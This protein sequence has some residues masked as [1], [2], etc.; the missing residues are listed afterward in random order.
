MFCWSL[1]TGGLKEQ[2]CRESQHPALYC[3]SPVII[4]VIIEVVFWPL[5]PA[6]LS[7]S[8][9]ALCVPRLSLAR[10]KEFMPSSVSVY[11]P[12]IEPVTTYSS[13]CNST[14]LPQG[15]YIK[16][17]TQP[18]RRSPGHSSESRS[19]IGSTSHRFG[20]SFFHNVGIWEVFSGP[21]ASCDVVIT[22]FGHSESRLQS[23]PLFLGACIRPAICQTGISVGRPV[24]S[25]LQLRV[26]GLFV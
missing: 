11:S 8:L 2:L 14:I 19:Q 3:T 17:R 12:L 5:K 15:R 22:L 18:W 4:E 21:G 24:H 26:H 10:H 6:V 1:W 25:T 20:N 7:G 9:G 16:T 23:L 13:A